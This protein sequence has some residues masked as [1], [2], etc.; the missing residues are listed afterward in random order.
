MSELYRDASRPVEERVDHLLSLMTPEEK[1]AQLGSLW[2]YEVLENSAFSTGKAGLRMKS[3]I[4]QITR[5]GGASSLDP[6]DGAKIANEIQRYLVSETRL[7]IPALVHEESC[8]GYMAKGATL[9]PQTI[10]VASTWNPDLT[11]KMGEVIRTQMKSVGAHQ[12]LAPLLDVTRDARWGRV[13]ETFGEDPY[14]VTQMGLSYVRGLQTED[15]R[16]GVIATGKHFV[17]YGVSEGGMNWAPPHIPARELR[18]VFLQPFEAVVRKGKLGSIMPGYHELDGVPCHASTS[19]LTDVLRK[20]WGFDGIVVSDYFAVD[21]L[22]SYHHLADDEGQA[23]RMALQTG[24]DVELPSIDCYGVPLVELM[25]QGVI[26]MELVDAAVRR[27]LTAKF[28][29]GLFEHPYVDESRV[30]EV[31]DNKEQR[32]LARTIAQQSIVLLKNEGNMLP[33]KKEVGTIAV[34]GPNANSVRHLLGDYAYPCHIETLQDMTNTFNTA[35]PEKIEL[36]LNFVAMRTVF[37]AIRDK[38]SA[39]TRVVF[40]QGMETL[41]GS[42]AGIDEAVAVAKE[43]DVAILVVGDKA[44]LIDGCSS[45]ES[46]DRASLDLPGMQEEL[47]RAVHA[48]GTPV[49]AVLANGRPLS[50]NWLNEHVPAILEAW[51]PGEEGADAIADVLFGDY[52]PGGRLPMSVPRSVG[53]VPVYYNHK[54][55]GGRSHWKGDYVEMSASPLYP[56]GYGL[57]YTEFAYSNLAVLDAPATVDGRVTILVDVT[58]T[59]AIAGE[60]VVQLYVHD[61]YA[62]VTR[63][64]KELKGFRRVALAAGETKTVRFVLPI[65]SL[66]FHNVDLN[67]VVE[68]GAFEVM[69][70][71]SSED[72]RLTGSFEVTGEPTIVKEREYTTEAF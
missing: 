58:N 18:D 4:G 71:S 57:S 64:V 36:D 25:E 38:V 2:V 23:A 56:F 60:E 34:I 33:L 7:G 3:G 24:V 49:V 61:P 27:V 11:E 21:M 17:G 53:Q 67:Y 70:G 13:E 44:G 9:F 40:A 59:G 37:E 43:A 10:G 12:A 8:S 26:D 41:T 45:G 14:L 55:S 68:P 54:P 29:M 39:E 20:E 42:Q 66:G 47:V 46:L 1:S 72:I 16:D 19:L 15:V 48:T 22:H 52:N 32:A 51:L 63:P 35:V 65:S 5:I 50:I 31:F 69:V 28:R 30:A 6:V 62:S